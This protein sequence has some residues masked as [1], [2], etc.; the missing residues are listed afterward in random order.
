MWTLHKRGYPVE[1][2]AVP[3]IGAEI[4]L[5]GT[6]NCA[7]RGCSARTSR[8]STRLSRESLCPL[9]VVQDYQRDTSK[10][11]E[12]YSLGVNAKAGMRE[13]HDQDLG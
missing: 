5:T 11:D 7:T 12:T 9:P 8:R 1:G 3:G 13:R 4:V 2:Q 10:R 6:G